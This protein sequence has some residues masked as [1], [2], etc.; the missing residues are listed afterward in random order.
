VWTNRYNNQRTGA[1]TVETQLTQASVTPGKFGLLFS[2]VVDGT[3][4]GQPLYVPGLTIQGAK[5]N[6][7]FVATFN[8]SIYAFDAD[9]PAAWAPLWVKSLGTSIATSAIR[10]A[11]CHDILPEI[12]ITS[13]PVIDLQTGILYTTA[14]TVEGAAYVHRLHALDILT[15]DE[16][17]GSPVEI[18]PT[19]AGTSPDSNGGII[20]FDGETQLQ[21]PGLL[22]DQ[23]VVYVAFG[24]HCDSQPYHGWVLAYDAASLTLR[25]TYVTTPAGRQGA[26]WQSGVGLSTDGTGIY[27]LSGNGDIDHTG[28]G[29]QLGVSVA[30]LTL[31]ANGLSVADFW[32]P[33]DA[34]SLNANDEDLTG[35]PIVGPGN[36][37]F[38][39]GKVSKLFV[40]NRRGLGGFHSGGDQIVQTLPH[41]G[42]ELHG[43]PVYWDGPAGPELFFWPTLGPLQSYL[44]DPTAA[45][46]PVKTAPL[47][48]SL[49]LNPPHPGGIVTVSSNGATPGTGVVWASVAAAG[50]D[51]WHS[52]VPG[53]LYA[54][55]A[56]DVTRVL[57]SSDFDPQD[58]LGLFAKFCP[59]TVVNGHVYIGTAIDTSVTPATGA[60][61][62]YGPVN[63]PITGPMPNGTYALVNHATGL[64]ADVT[65]GS[66]APG[67]QVIQWP[68]TNGANQH[69][70][71]QSPD[72]GGLTLLNVNSNLV[73]DVPG[74]AT[75][76]TGVDQAAPTGSA[77]QQWT[78]QPA[79]TPGYFVVTSGGGNV[80]L[81][82]PSSTEGVELIVSAPTA[83]P[84][85]SASASQEWQFVQVP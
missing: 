8:D 71:L 83:T 4:Q 29:A 59:P 16:R 72:G 10:A 73:L 6:V 28:N 44:V 17:A 40:L 56:D 82:S 81:A 50:A 12:G 19:A 78:I 22:L 70:T 61:R 41:P 48:T 63:R 54:F 35:G 68:A 57:W 67:A 37:L 5:H 30:R 36:L 75:P 34:D 58:A 2:R 24:S 79:S 13:T 32:T 15:G 64:V 80:V 33:A 26:I 85:A 51:A 11:S 27:F 3:I 46:N 38:A 45:T 1:T 7:V 65:G 9:D 18:H 77:L 39:G 84:S 25:G 52:V 60:L 23:G 31:G 43:G 20:S 74:A 53:T 66:T 55:S 76:G 21:R 69:W 14:K 49:P 62:V 47:G 42:S